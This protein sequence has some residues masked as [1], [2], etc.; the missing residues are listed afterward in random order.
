MK[1]LQEEKAAK[2]GGEIKEKCKDILQKQCSKVNKKLLVSKVFYYFFWSAYGSFFPLLGVYYK[3]IGM[4]PTQSGILVGC[5][6]LIEFISAPSLGSL[7]DRLNIRKVMLLF[8]LCCWIA[9]VFPIGM[10]KPSDKTCHRYLMLAKN[11]SEITS[12]ET[13]EVNE[14]LKKNTPHEEPIKPHRKGNVVFSTDSIHPE[15]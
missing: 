5:R 10:I 11:I 8:N 7:A 12:Q 15:H 1:G 14:F 2:Y 3:Q 6:P 4:N 9:F 13:D